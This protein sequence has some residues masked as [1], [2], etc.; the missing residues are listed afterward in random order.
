MKRLLLVMV[1]VLIAVLAVVAFSTQY[2]GRVVIKFGEW[3]YIASFLDFSIFLIGLFLISAILIRLSTFVLRMPSQLSAAIG[4]S[5]RKHALKKLGEGLSAYAGGDYKRAT[6]A[7]GKTSALGEPLN[8]AVNML[9]VRCKI[10]CGSVGEARKALNKARRTVADSEL[11]DLLQIEIEASGQPPE[12]TV[13]KLV[14]VIDHNPDNLRAIEYL[15]KLCS[16]KGLWTIGGETFLRVSAAL[17]LAGEDSLDALSR[18]VGVLMRDAADRKD[19]QRLQW[20]WRNCD[21]QVRA[22]TEVDYAANMMRVG[23]LGKGERILKQL[24]EGDWDR[25]AIESFTSAAIAEGVQERLEQVKKWLALHPDDPVLMA[26]AARLYQQ[27]GLSAQAREYFD[28]S[29]ALQPDYKVWCEAGSVKP[30]SN[31]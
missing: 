10:Y 20:L 25:R 15:Q 14:Q 29:L 17:G 16:E 22:R 2:K 18:V 1:S 6:A 27:C 31:N 30:T 12:V 5:Y 28:K 8:G 19:G 26:A 3:E 24:I 13:R 23:M 7:F 11:L 21:A 4:R 9:L